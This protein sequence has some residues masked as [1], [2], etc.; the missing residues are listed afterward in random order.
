MKEIAKAIAIDGPSGAGK[1]SVAKEVAKALDFQYID[2]GAMYR[3]VT[4]KVLRKN[5]NPE[6]E[7]AVTAVAKDCSVVLSTKNGE[8]LVLL[9]GEDVSTEIRGVD[10]TAKVSVVCSYQGVRSAM[11][12]QQRAMASRCGVVMDGRD[13]GTHVLPNALLKI[14]LTASQAERGRRRYEEWRQKGVS[15]MTLEEVIADIHRRDTL[16]STREVSPLKQGHDAVL[17]DSDGLTVKETAEKVIDL[18]KERI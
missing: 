2:T 14:F 15:D 18:W 13:I 12:T 3:A 6:D 16:D 7:I 1:S 8:T 11:V 4:L 10:V 9:D 17:L 5:V